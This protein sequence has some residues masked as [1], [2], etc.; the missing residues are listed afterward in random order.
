MKLIFDPI[1]KYMEFEKELLDVIDTYEFQRLRYIKQLG[2]CYF[3]F[4]GASHNRFEHSLG[5]AHLS[6]KMI[7]SLQMRQPELQI[8][9]RQCILIKIAGLVHD[10]G[11]V[12]FS[13]FFDHKLLSLLDED[14]IY[15][16]H[17][18]RSCKIFEF[19]VNKYKLNFSKEE[20][21][22]VCNL[23]HPKKN[24]K[25]FLYQIVA[26]AK[27]GI[28]CD[29]FDYLVRDARNIGLEF[30]IDYLRLID[31]CRVIDDEICYPDKLKFNIYNIFY[32]R[33]RLHKQ[34]Y[35]HPVVH[36]LEY[37]ILDILINAKDYLKIEEN[38]NNIEYYLTLTDNILDKI[39][40]SEDKSLNIS[41]KILEKLY[42]RDIYK[43]IEEDEI[44]NLSSKNDI[45]IVDETKLSLSKGNI[46]P[47]TLVS[48]YKK[49]DL[50]QKFSIKMKDVSGL[51]PQSCE[52]V[53][54]RYFVKA[55][56]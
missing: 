13:H 10:I 30:T 9:D 17:E 5:V 47:I 23:I 11:H 24:C 16:E 43:F 54:K 53:V 6:H 33:Y 32:T 52:E 34:I 36:G 46:N 41:K 8:T 48:F 21:L 1:H 4:P 14:N 29:K 38:L 2:L 26:N 3:V 37:M 27:N 39:R 35:T 7:K 40:F 55:I 28:D 42:T 15:K 12:C 31:E 20:I 19:I 44:K 51:V 49:S 22:F 56:L 45:L 18:D 50:N 25:G